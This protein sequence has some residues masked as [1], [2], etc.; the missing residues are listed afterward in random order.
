ML[1]YNVVEISEVTEEMLQ[2]VLNHWTSAGWRFDGLHF[3]VK[4]TARRPSMAFVLFVRTSRET[5]PQNEP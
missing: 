3:V 4:E 1:E 2:D 5:R